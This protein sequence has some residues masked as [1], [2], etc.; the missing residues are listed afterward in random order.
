MVGVRAL[1]C[2]DPLG[3]LQYFIYCQAKDM[4]KRVL[5]YCS[6]TD[7]IIDRLG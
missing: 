4:M 2:T 7:N 3:A 5:H 6:D 1:N